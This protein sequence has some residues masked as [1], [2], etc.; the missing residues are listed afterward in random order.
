MLFRKQRVEDG[1]LGII[2]ANRAT[3]NRIFLQADIRL[4]PFKIWG[5]QG[6]EGLPF[7]LLGCVSV[8]IWHQ[9]FV[10]A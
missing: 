2:S 1:W 7:C 10:G 5:S 9:H 3:T 8:F 6:S 4:I